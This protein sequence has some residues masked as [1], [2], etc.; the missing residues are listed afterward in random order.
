MGGSVQ[1]GLRLTAVVPVAVHQ[2]QRQQESEASDGV[3]ARK[4]GLHAL[5]P[6]HPD[7]DV[8]ALDHIDVIRAVTDG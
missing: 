5:L 7:P 4:N 6:P 3:I 8:R 2:Q 1:D